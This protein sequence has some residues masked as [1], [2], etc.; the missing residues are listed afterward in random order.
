PGAVYSGVVVEV[1][2]IVPDF[3][4]PAGAEDAF[5]VAVLVEF[6][7]LLESAVVD[8]AFE[9]HISIMRRASQAEKGVKL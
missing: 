4:G 7:G 6:D 2:K 3:D 5:I 8:P 9:G 1:G